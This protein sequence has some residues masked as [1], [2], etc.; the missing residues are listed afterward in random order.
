MAEKSTVEKLWADIK[1]ARRNIKE[2]VLHVREG[3]PLSEHSYAEVRTFILSA[4]K[5]IDE[6]CRHYEMIYPER[7]KSSE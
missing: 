7:P 3:N 6:A 1:D 5:D 2:A 4:E